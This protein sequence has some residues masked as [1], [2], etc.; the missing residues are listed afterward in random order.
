MT[1]YRLPSGG[2]VDRSR[3]ISFT[4]DDTRYLGFTGDTVASALMARGERIVGRSF[5]YHRARGI[6][7]AGVEES[8]AVVSLWKGPERIANVKA[9]QAEIVPGLE[10]WGQNAWPSV[11]LDLGSV[12][13]LM[14][15]FFGA[16]FYYKTFFGITG[17][18]TWE[19]MQFEKLIRRAA[20]MGRASDKPDP[21]Q[22]EIVHDHCDVLVIGSGPAGLSAASVLASGGADVILAEQDFA[23]GGS[24]LTGLSG[25]IDGGSADAWL[26]GKV[27]DLE[28]NG[29]RIWNR[30]T[31]F[32][33]YDHGVVGLMERVTDHRERA[34]H[35]P[36]ERF[37]IV[38]ARR[39]VLATGAV[40]RPFAFGD[41]DRP[42]VMLAS[43]AAAYVTR[44]GVA[45]GKRAV[46]GVNNDSGYASAMILARAG[47]E[48]TVLDARTTPPRETAIATREA[49]IEVRSGMVPVE[50]RGA[51]GV[52]ALDIGRYDGERALAEDRVPCDVI[53][54]AGGWTP[55]MHLIS[56]KGVKPVWNE[57]QSAFIVEDTGIE[58]V[59]IAGSAA[60]QFDT[61][62]VVAAGVKA[63]EEALRALQGKRHRALPG[64]S[65]DWEAP[66]HPLWEVSDPGRKLK[67]FVDPQHD[68]TTD[69]VRLAH[70]EGYVSVEHMKRYTT[71]GMATDQGKMG[72][73]I[74][75]ALMAEA[76]GASIPDTGTTTFRPPY[77]PVSIG[78]L[79]GDERGTHWR[80]TRHSPMRAEHERL[81]CKFVDAGFWK[82]SWYYPKGN[83]GLAE[84]AMR[85]AKIV[86]ANV[87][88]VDVSSLGKIM[89]QGPD[90]AE[91][92]NRVYSN[93]FAKLPIGKARYGLMLR[94]DGIVF[95]DGTT[96]RLSETDYFMTTTTANAGPVM[97]H[98]ANLLQTRWPDLRIH[99]TSVSDHWGGVAVAG[100]KARE[101]L[102]GACSDI[103]FSDEAFPFMG[104]RQ[105]HLRAETGS[106]IPVMTARLSFSGEMAWEVMA[107][108]DHCGAMFRALN[109]RITAAWGV[110][111]G[112]EAMDCM[113]VE[114]GH[115]TGRELDGRTTAADVGLGMMASQKKHYVGRALAAR[116]DLVRQDRPTLVGLVPVE[117]GARFKAGSILFP[118]GEASGHGLGHVSSIADSPEL[119]SWI[120]LGFVSGGLAE[121][122]GK[123]IVAENPIDSQSTPVRVVSPHFYDPKGERMHG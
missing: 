27:S 82:R 11:R 73:V 18:G 13:N 58:P 46:I 17:K 98:L 107:P 114:K 61:A 110:P 99:I 123:E 78:A 89:V 19:W 76:T 4:W 97:L 20:G 87:G 102:Q 93:P 91:F 5:K 116:P 109:S 51:R 37:R 122:E 43:G 65:S 40:E 86:R 74:G 121:W 23:L 8:G 113:R 50:A 67:R 3:S 90:A 69:D 101:V 112:L 80:P 104:V 57:D 25:D 14:G 77:T 96:W 29:V 108:A 111:Y 9:T 62:S 49:G 100:P 6:M 70:S 79:A 30:T 28:G 92:L 7:S 44:F 54:V 32:G 115:V 119:G 26:S 95:D 56:H 10:V 118:P 106:D 59:G 68:V 34:D 53:G 117:S 12:N 48:T 31:A 120:G 45:P 94:D 105:G 84:A 66:L 81:G 55:V 60:G 103:D 75:L 1:G 83:E 47:I 64:P 16:G 41:N 52:H 36:R 22:Y 21:D 42:G 39:I 88:M 35:L 33:L 85:E 63:G 72:N 15:R 71:L 24:A 38:R 2:Q